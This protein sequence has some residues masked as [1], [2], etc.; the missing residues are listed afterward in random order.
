MATTIRMIANDIDGVIE[1][2]KGGLSMEDS[3]Y[4]LMIP[5]K[6]INFL[7]TLGF[8]T[9]GDIYYASTEH[10]DSYR[11]EAKA[12]FRPS[13]RVQQAFKE[14]GLIWPVAITPPME[15]TPSKV[16][17]ASRKR[18]TNRRKKK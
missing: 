12:C 13:T 6:D 18:S 2:A 16:S 4:E 9:V 5:E 14:R 7:M 17:Q 8:E 3:I 15:K 1:R 11:R 10:V